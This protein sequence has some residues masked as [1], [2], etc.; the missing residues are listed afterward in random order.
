VE[1]NYSM[2]GG[3]DVVEFRHALP[4]YMMKHRGFNQPQGDSL[5][6]QAALENAAELR[7]LL[8]PTAK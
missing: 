8:P 7:A 6:K 2:V 1:V 3:K 4:F 5:T